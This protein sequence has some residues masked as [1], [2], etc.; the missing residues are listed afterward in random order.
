MHK[1]QIR[2]IFASYSIK[3]DPNDRKSLD[4]LALVTR[5]GVHLEVRKGVTIRTTVWASC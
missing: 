3:G 5:N 2:E 1:G 4:L